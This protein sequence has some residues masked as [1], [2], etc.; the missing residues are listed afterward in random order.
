MVSKEESV[1]EKGKKDS[2]RENKRQGE[3]ERRWKRKRWQERKIE[4][5]M[6]R[7]R[8]GRKEWGIEGEWPLDLFTQFN[9]KTAFNWTQLT[10]NISSKS[11][12]LHTLNIK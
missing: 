8:D 6:L 11:N 7:G 9:N 5:K 12:I 4:R 10:K 3:Q 1:K 2:W